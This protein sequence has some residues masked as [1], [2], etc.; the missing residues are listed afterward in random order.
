MRYVLIA[1]VL[2]IKQL[3][4]TQVHPCSWWVQRGILG[5]QFSGLSRQVLRVLEHPHW[6]KGVNVV[7]P[8][9]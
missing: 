2:I 7:A 1:N 9:C 6:L 4:Y 3:K 8:V 5:Y